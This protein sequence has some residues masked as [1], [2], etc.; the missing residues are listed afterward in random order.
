MTATP[1]APIKKNAYLDVPVQELKVTRFHV[2][3]VTPPTAVIT[4]VGEDDTFMDMFLNGVDPAHAQ[5]ILSPGTTFKMALRV[6][7]EP[8]LAVDKDG[9]PI[10]TRDGVQLATY[11][12]YP[13]SVATDIKSA[14]T[15]KKAFGLAA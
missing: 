3:N 14:L 10:T 15:A 4:V 9:Q 6:A 2:A 13:A 5:D 8:K 12:A 11:R 1:N 7:E